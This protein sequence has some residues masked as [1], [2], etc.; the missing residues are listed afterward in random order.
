MPAHDLPSPH[1]LPTWLDPAARQALE[2]LQQES[3]GAWV[4]VPHP[5]DLTWEQGLAWVEAMAD[6]GQVLGLWGALAELLGD[7]WPAQAR[8]LRLACTADEEEEEAFEPPSWLHYGVGDAPLSQGKGLRG[9]VRL[10][11][12]RRSA[13]R[14]LE[15]EETLGTSWHQ[16]LMA[17]TPR[18]Q[19]R[20]AA[21]FGAGRVLATA[22][23]V[24]AVLDRAKPVPFP[25]SAARAESWLPVPAWESE[26]DVFVLPSPQRQALGPGVWVELSR[27]WRGQAEVL[28]WAVLNRHWRALTAPSQR[29]PETWGRWERRWE[30]GVGPRGLDSRFVFEVVAPDRAW[31]KACTAQAQQMLAVAGSAV[32]LLERFSDPLFQAP[33]GEQVEA[34]V[35]LVWP[36]ERIQAARQAHLLADLPAALGA[37]RLR[38]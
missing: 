31:A 33:L 19:D 35:E 10:R 1:Q 36:V 30:S 18:H 38:L 11:D 28:G 9:E 5:D 4:G 2:S 3:G 20:L 8:A 13:W 6:Y 27:F 22:S 34:V 17:Y 15:H 7:S 26:P 21:L 24:R 32:R 25:A 16:A 37:A 23:D 12:P 14:P 29:P